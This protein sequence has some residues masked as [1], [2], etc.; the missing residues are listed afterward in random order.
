MR[1]DTLRRENPD[2]YVLTNRV[3]AVPLSKI[4]IPQKLK[5]VELSQDQQYSLKK[6]QGVLVKTWIRRHIPAKNPARR[7]RTSSN[8]IP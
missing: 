5:S 6:D 7:S 4:Q 2:T 3:E 8:A 1:N